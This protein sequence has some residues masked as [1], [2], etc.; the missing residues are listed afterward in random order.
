[1]PKRLPR[2]RTLKGDPKLAHYDSGGGTAGEPPILLIHASLFRS[3]DWENIF[4]RLATRYRVVAYDQRGHGKSGRASGYELRAFADDAERMLREIVKSPAV[5]IGHSLGALCAIVCAAEVPELVRAIVLE[6]PPLKY[7]TPWERERYQGL[8]DA[9]DLRE[10]PKA[11]MRAVEKR[12]LPSPGPRGERTYGEMRGFYA[13]ER[14]VTYF[15]DVDP[16]FLDQRM[17]SDDSTAAVIA[18]S[19]GRI[20]CPVLV[21]TGEARLGAAFDDAAE[22]TLKR[23]IKDLTVKRFAGQGHIIHG[24]RP[25]PFLETLEPFLRRVRAT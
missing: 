12:P 3:E 24:F 16:A 10:D 5:I 13:A 17:S 20:S 6:D 22:F 15:T 25:E 4:P 1:M 7:G 19:I 2:A 18:R 21:I 9:L 8:R 11:F 14:V 23:Q